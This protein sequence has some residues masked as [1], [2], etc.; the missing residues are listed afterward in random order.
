MNQS[1]LRIYVP[2]LCPQKQCLSGKVDRLSERT[3]HSLPCVK[4]AD[5]EGGWGIVLRYAFA[6]TIPPSRFREPP[7]FTQGRLSYRPTVHLKGV[8]HYTLRA[9]RVKRSTNKTVRTPFV[10]GRG[11]AP[12]GLLNSCICNGGT[13]APPY[14]VD[15]S[16]GKTCFMGSTRSGWFCF[17]GELGILCASRFFDRSVRLPKN[18][19][20]SWLGQPPCLSRQRACF[21]EPTRLLTLNF[22]SSKQKPPSSGWFCFGGELGIRT[23][24]TFVHSISSAAPSTTRTTLRIWSY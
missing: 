14:K 17:G 10:V 12:A 18:L 4:G 15:I 9:R 13:K 23:L 11:L 1:T 6:F 7:P 16:A 5:A 2:P 8:T 19:R 22:S 24:G 3:N 21:D 20:C